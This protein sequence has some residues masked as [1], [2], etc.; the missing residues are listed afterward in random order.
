VAYKK[1]RYARTNEFLDIVGLEWTSRGPFNYNGRF[2][3]IE[4][5][6]SQVKP[7]NTKSLKAEPMGPF[8]HPD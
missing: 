5:G 7:H 4:N 8:A 1:E 2:Y 3:M 6:F